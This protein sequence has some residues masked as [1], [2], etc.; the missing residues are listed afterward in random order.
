MSEEKHKIVHY[1]AIAAAVFVGAFASRMA[2]TYVLARVAISQIE[3]IGEQAHEDLRRINEKNTR[4]ARAVEKPQN[5]SVV[6]R[7]LDATSIADA[8]SIPNSIETTVV[9]TPMSSA[10]R[11]VRTTTPTWSP[12]SAQDSFTRPTGSLCRVERA[13]MASNWFSGFGKIAG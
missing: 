13:R 1:I 7:K 12:E 4:Q 6:N 2:Y 3:A 9:I 11:P 8:Q 5:K 10:E